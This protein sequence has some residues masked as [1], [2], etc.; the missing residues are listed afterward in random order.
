MANK[1]KVVLFRSNNIFDSRV[2]KYHNYYEREGIDYTIVGWD[3]KDE[4]LQK[5]N[6]DFF[7]YKAGE[8]EGGMKAM[9]NHFRWMRFVYRYLKQHNDVTTIHSCDLNSAFPAAVFKT[10]H[11]RRV[12]LIFD[13][14]DWFSANFSHYKLLH[15]LFCWM[16]RF[17][18]KRAN[19]LIIC[20]EERKEQIQFKLKK[21]PLVMRNI[22][23]I[24]MSQITAV[25]ER[26]KF[27]NEKPTL[28]YMGGFSDARFLMELL[29]LA[30]TEPFNLLIAGYG[31]KAIMQKCEELDKRDNVKYFGRVNMVDGLNMENAADVVYAMYCKVNPNHV[32]AAPNKYYEAMLLGKPLITTKGTIPGDK[33][34][35]NDTGWTVEEDI[36]E[37]KQVLNNLNREEIGTKGANA[38]KLWDEHYKDD[39]RN[40]FDKIYSKVIK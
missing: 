16:E 12:T 17:T 36:E 19:E 18:Y 30:E 31:D 22:P 24:D 15:L 27:Y 1:M 20:E 2:N 4:G 7:R 25:Q 13:A 33:V 26:F 8:A 23:E 9:K 39:L 10:L 34:E 3:R 32:Y 29:T 35:R 14:C 37:M 28:A 21:E 6:Y 38:L 11:K 5:P 40:F